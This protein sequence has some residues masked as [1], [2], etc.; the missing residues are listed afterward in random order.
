MPISARIE[1]KSGD[2]ITTVPGYS[3]PKQTPKSLGYAITRIAAKRYPKF[4]TIPFK[5]LHLCYKTTLLQMKLFGRVV[6]SN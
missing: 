6:G 1:G 2:D 4:P 5:L 3:D